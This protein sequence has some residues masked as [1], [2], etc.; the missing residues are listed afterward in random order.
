MFQKEA[1]LLFDVINDGVESVG[2]KEYYSSI[3]NCADWRNLKQT[4]HHK[5]VPVKLEILQKSKET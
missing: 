4:M 5:L 1:K 3:T 2:Y